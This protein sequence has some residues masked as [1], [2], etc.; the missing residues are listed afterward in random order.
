MLFW[1]WVCTLFYSGGAGHFPGNYTLHY[2]NT[3][4]YGA[5]PASANACNNRHVGQHL[6]LFVL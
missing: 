1:I 3:G 5:F 2:S 6:L 4:Q